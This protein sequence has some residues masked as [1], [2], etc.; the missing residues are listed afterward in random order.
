MLFDADILGYFQDVPGGSA[1]SGKIAW[2]PGPKGPDGKRQTNMWIWSLAMNSKS[3]SKG[4]AWYF[5]QW[6]TGKEHLLKGAL[7]AHVDPV[8]KSVMENKDFKAR[9]ATHTN[10]YETFTTIIDD[11]D[12][13]FTPQ[14]KF[15]ETTTEWASTLH[16]I[17]Y[18]KV[19]TKQG[20]D[21]L[22]SKIRRM[23][24]QAGVRPGVNLA[25]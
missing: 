14:P 23:L 19:S 9:L 8:R 22:A 5:I 12:I 25:K 10:F 6:A 17:Y 3:K 1:C 18:G 15:F 4:P 16:D 7:Q 2:A 13:L 21:M 20:L 11:T 24:L